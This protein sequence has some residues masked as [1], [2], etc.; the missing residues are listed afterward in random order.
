MSLDISFY[1]GV[2]CPHCGEILESNNELES[3]NITH[4]LGEMADKAGIYEALWRPYRLLDDYKAEMDF[5]N[6]NIVFAK[7]LIEPLEDGLVELVAD[8]E[9]FKQFDSPNGWGIYDDFV[10]FVGNVLATCIKY[11]NSIVK[12][13]R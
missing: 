1:E 4:N 13:C 10:P 7:I 2:K 5:E 12:C 8:P 9:Y 11:P 3:F 6:N